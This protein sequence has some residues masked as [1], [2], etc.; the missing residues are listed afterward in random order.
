MSFNFVVVGRVIVMLKFA[1]GCCAVF[2][3]LFLLLL[4]YVGSLLFIL[5]FSCTYL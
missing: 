3:L 5:G 1:C 4:L 2:D